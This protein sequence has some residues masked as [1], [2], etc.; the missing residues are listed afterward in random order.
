MVHVSRGS[1][2]FRKEKLI[3]RSQ[4]IPSLLRDKDWGTSNFN[5]FM[6]YKRKPQACPSNVQD[7]TIL[8]KH[9]SCH[10]LYW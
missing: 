4:S 6:G 7:Y 10:M 8:R 9:F 1:P 5:N 2:R 3:K